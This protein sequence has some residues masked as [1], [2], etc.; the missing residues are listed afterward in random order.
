[1]GKSDK[2]R[3]KHD[4]GRLKNPPGEDSRAKRKCPVPGCSTLARTDN[5]RNHYNSL[6]VYDQNGNALDLTGDTTE[7]KKGVKEHT[8]Y[9]YEKG[10]NRQNL[11]PMNP[12]LGADVNP[13]TLARRQTGIAQAPGLVEYSDE[14]DSDDGEDKDDS[15]L[16]VDVSVPGRMPSPY[17]SDTDVNIDSGGDT[18]RETEDEAMADESQDG[19]SISNRREV[20][21]ESEQRQAERLAERE[22]QRLMDVTGGHRDSTILGDDHSSVSNEDVVNNEENRRDEEMDNASREEEAEGEEA[23][24]EEQARRKEQDDLKKRNYKLIAEQI[25]EQLGDTNLADQI[26]KKVADLINKPQPQE[27]ISDGGNW[28]ETETEMICSDCLSYAHHQSLPPALKS[29]RKGSVGVVKKDQDPKHLKESIKKHENSSLHIWCHKK[30]ERSRENLES[31]RRNNL[32]AANMIVTNVLYCLKNSESSVSFVKLCDKDELNEDITFATKN[33]G[34]E[35]FFQLRD[36]V[37]EKLTDQLVETLHNVNLLTVTLDK[38]TCVNVSYTVIVSYFFWEGRVRCVLNE[39]KV[40]SSV[41]GDGEGSAIMLATALMQ[42]LRLTKASLARIL[43]H[44]VYDGVYA[45]TSERVRGGGSLSLVAHLTAYL[46][47]EPGVITGHWD[48]GHKMELAYCKIFKSDS[49]DPVIKKLVEDHVYA[50]MSTYRDGK[51]N[52]LFKELA[53]EL[54]H[55]VIENQGKAQ[56]TRWV[57]SFLRALKALFRNAATF[58]VFL[59]RE[60][61]KFANEFNIR[62]QRQCQK[63]LDKL[64]DGKTWALLVGVCQ[65]LD[66]FAAASVNSQ[67]S[68]HFAT[69]GVDHVE[70]ALSELKSLAENWVWKVDVLKL[71]EMGCPAEIVD[72]LKAGFYRPYVTQGAKQHRVRVLN[73]ERAVRRDLVAEVEHDLAHLTDIVAWDNVEDVHV[74]DIQVGEISVEDFNDEVEQEA[75]ATLKLCCQDLVDEWEERLQTSTLMKK[76]RDLFDRYDWYIVGDDDSIEMAENKLI[77]VVNELHNEEEEFFMEHRGMLLRGFHM[78]I[79]LWQTEMQNNKQVT[80]EELYPKYWKMYNKNACGAVFI[81]FFEHIQLKSYSEAICETIGNF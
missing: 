15:D 33:D 4:K 75:V 30:A 49:A 50:I 41:D 11:P 27:D 34:Q 79:V 10:Y 7:R 81:R 62:D 77:A 61:E 74:D 56:R 25:V 21:E 46:G 48:S 58:Y 44:V 54:L 63:K 68:S 19:A 42:S 1:M 29:S 2:K 8:M 59:G 14:E 80:L 12:V 73:V 76:A 3:V 13:F 72:N 57:R 24:R 20:L 65:I 5:L 17:D 67:Y 69:T 35:V 37:F 64:K 47:L 66:I 53:E 43:R 28:K 55:P 78:W 38:V 18:L 32:K 71:G 23:A 51:D 70:R 6:V 39:L 9:F 26:A 22:S 52:V 60:C 45:D 36:V 40:M 31:E 16:E